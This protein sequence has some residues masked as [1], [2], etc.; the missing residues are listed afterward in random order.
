MLQNYSKWSRN[1]QRFYKWSKK[2]SKI[3][4]NDSRSIRIYLGFKIIQNYPRS[5]RFYWDSKMLIF[6]FFSPLLKP[7]DVDPT[8]LIFHNLARSHS[9]ISNIDRQDLSTPTSPTFSNLLSSRS[10]RCIQI[11]CFKM[12]RGV[13]GVFQSTLA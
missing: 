6:L 13:S 4:S 11:I 7:I 10:L 12:F 5:Q 2:L 1:C 8:K 3:Y 9:N